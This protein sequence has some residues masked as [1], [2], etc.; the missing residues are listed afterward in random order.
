M[1]PAAFKQMPGID[2]QQ[3]SGKKSNP[4]PKQSF[5]D[6]VDQ[7]YGQNSA[8]SSGQAG[9]LDVH[10]SEGLKRYQRVHEKGG[11]I[12]TKAFRIE[13]RPALSLCIQASLEHTIGIPSVSG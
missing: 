3:S 12:C 7:H 4:R 8:Q 5:T 10:A 9:R 13:N 1:P 11:N 6:V 2:G